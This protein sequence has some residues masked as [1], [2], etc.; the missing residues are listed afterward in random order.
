MKDEKSCDILVDAEE[1][2][3]KIQQP[4][5]IKTLSTV[6]IEGTY[7]NIIKAIYDKLT[8]NVIFNRKKPKIVSLKIRNSRGMSTFTTL[9]QHSTGSPSHSKLK[10]NKRH[11]NWK[12]RSNTVIICR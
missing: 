7:L 1:A 6:R 5:M 8:A 2:Y 9:I 10:R 3:D 4:F 12:G 11:P